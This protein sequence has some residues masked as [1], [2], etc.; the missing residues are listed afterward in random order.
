MTSDEKPAPRSNPFQV[1]KEKLGDRL[2]PGPGAITPAPP[3]A[4]PAGHA[5]VS[6]ARVTVRQERAGRGGKTVTL[7][8]GPGLASARLAELARD[9]A[10]A[11]GVGARAEGGALVLQG[12]QRERLAAWLAARGFG[13]VVRGN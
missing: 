2:P 1:L 12:D 3:S 4:K 7:A 10:R 11:L 5:T 6:Q 8:D 13:G 9:A